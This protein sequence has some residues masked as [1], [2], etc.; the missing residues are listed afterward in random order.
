MR[1]RILTYNVHKCVGGVDRRCSP[2]RIAKTIARYRPDVVLLQEVV[3][4]AA[5]SA[6]ERQ[7]DVLG[8]LLGYRHRVF[9]PHVTRRGGGQYGNAVLSRF[10]ITEASHIDLTVPLKKRRAGVHSRI[11]LRPASG[12]PRTLH[13]YN[14]H[15]GLSGVE[16]KIQLRRLL[17]SR[18]FA[19][20]HAR[21]PVVV[22]GDFND[23]WG[24]LGRKVLAPA[25]FR[26]VPERLFTFPAFAPM[27]P[28]DTF[29]VRGDIRIARARRARVKVARRASDHLP[30]IADMVL[31]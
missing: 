30:V 1:F 20:T 10:P 12:H 8:D 21:A 15:L 27:R 22:G 24:T 5:G 17:D 6:D 2:S 14:L 25:G 23:V 7:V 19:G 28:F 18:L 13:V 26:G 9:F 3:G 29:Y 11:R 16:R 31:D 4:P